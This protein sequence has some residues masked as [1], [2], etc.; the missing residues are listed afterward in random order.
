MTG[1]LPIFTDEETKAECHRA[2]ETRTQ[3][4]NCELHGV[5]RTK[6]CCRD[7]E[8]G[9]EEVT[10][11]PGGRQWRKEIASG[12]FVHTSLQ[13]RAVCLGT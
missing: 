1:N 2:G 3:I 9:K 4:Q 7:G 6:A 12:L 5:L 13:I 8:G 11:V 10:V